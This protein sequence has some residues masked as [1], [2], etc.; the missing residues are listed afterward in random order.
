MKRNQNLEPEVVP[1]EKQQKVWRIEDRVLGIRGHW[2]PRAIVSVPQRELTLEHDIADE[3]LRRIVVIRDVTNEKPLPEPVPSKEIKP[4]E[5]YEETVAEPQQQIE[6]E[7]LD[8]LVSVGSIPSSDPVFNEKASSQNYPDD[9]KRI[10]DNKDLTDHRSPITGL[11]SVALAKEEYQSPLL[12]FAGDPVSL[13]MIV[14]EAMVPDL[15]QAQIL[16]LPEPAYPVLCRKRGEE[17]RVV[18]EIEISAKGKVLKAEVANSS[19]YAKLDRAAQKAV[20]RGS[21]IPAMEFGRPVESQ[22]TVAYV[23]RLENK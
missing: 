18:I 9:L 17:G 3:H 10:S 23:F 19:S 13:G 16:F 8:P 6:I 1:R 11:S 22:R 14:H 21:F 12:A 4:P 20:E 7:T 2:L 5:Q 15:V